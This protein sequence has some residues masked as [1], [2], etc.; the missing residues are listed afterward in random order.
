MKKTVLVLLAIMGIA[1][2]ISAGVVQIELGEVGVRPKSV[3]CESWCD[4]Q[5]MYATN[6]PGRHCN[7]QACVDE[8]KG[9]DPAK[10]NV[11]RNACMAK[12]SKSSRIN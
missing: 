10:I 11:E 2:T 3:S 5:S 1:F 8:C 9:K 4:Q 12:A 6:A 7:Y